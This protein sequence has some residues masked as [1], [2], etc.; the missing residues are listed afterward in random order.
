MD[1]AAQFPQRLKELREA[2]GISQ[3][4]L[5]ELCGLTRQ[6]IYMYEDGQ[7]VPGLS[8]LIAI[9]DCLDVSIDRLVGREKIF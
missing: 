2:K 6:T 1:M 4:T 7:R 9:A 3:Q 5:G 8:A